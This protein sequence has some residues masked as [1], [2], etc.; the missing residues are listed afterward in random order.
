MA[1]EEEKT[2]EKYEMKGP[3][4]FDQSNLSTHM[5]IDPD[6][7]NKLQQNPAFLKMIKQQEEEQKYKNMSPKEKL[8]T[9]LKQKQMNRMTEKVKEVVISEEP[10]KSR[11]KKTN[12]SMQNE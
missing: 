9:R 11:M 6:M 3:T 10:R 7:V 12:V 2:T 1:T 4:L 8:R 5:N